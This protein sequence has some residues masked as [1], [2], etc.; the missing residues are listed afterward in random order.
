MIECYAISY[1]HEITI[2][3]IYKILHCLACILDI[4]LRCFLRFMLIRYKIKLLHLSISVV[5]INIIPCMI[6]AIFLV[7]LMCI[8]T[9]LHIVCTMLCNKFL[10]LNLFNIFL[11]QCLHNSTEYYNIFDNI[12]II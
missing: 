5:M 12:K 3:H 11:F 4:D 1:V 10:V 9:H 2:I 6:P 8:N 7:L